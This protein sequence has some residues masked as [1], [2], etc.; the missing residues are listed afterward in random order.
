MILSQCY[1]PKISVIIL[2][3]LTSKNKHPRLAGCPFVT[4][5]KPSLKIDAWFCLE[6]TRII[7][8]VVYLSVNGKFCIQFWWLLVN[9]TW[10]NSDAEGQRTIR[11]VTYTA[12][13]HFCFLWWENKHA[14]EFSMLGLYVTRGHFPFRRDT[15]VLWLPSGCLHCRPVIAKGDQIREDKVQFSKGRGGIRSV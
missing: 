2:L 7:S 15:L 14:M 4:T 11:S 9:V 1:D 3:Q 5:C 8:C 13:Y 12:L 10:I 6:E